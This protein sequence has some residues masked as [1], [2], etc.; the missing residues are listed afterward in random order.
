[1]AR[2]RTILLTGAAGV[3]GRAIAAQLDGHCIALVHDSRE[4]PEAGEVLAGDLS[5]PRLGLS[6]EDWHRL[7]GTVTAIVHS[8][9]LT[10]W[11]RPR[12]RYEAINLA[13]T[14]QVIELAQAAGA[15][16]YFISTI[17][18]LA[19]QR[20][21]DALKDDNVVRN[22]IWSKLE[23]ERL[24][25][26]S[27]VPHTIFRPTN[28]VGDSQ[29][30]ASL[31]PQIVQVLSDFIV[32]GKAPYFPSHPENLVD[33]A[34][35][36]YLA[37]PVARMAD[38]DLTGGTFHISYGDSAMSVDTALEVLQEHARDTGRQ[39]GRA[40]VVDPREPLPV[41]LHEI[42]ATSRPFVKV[43]IDV[44]EVTFASG[45]VLPSSLGELRERFDLSDTSP[46]VA[47]DRGLK[48]WAQQRG[49]LMQGVPSR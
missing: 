9:A 13:G 15:P 47:F 21:P 16:V 42:K 24:L 18:V 11:G 29:T 46:Q 20:S 49:Q 27:D 32:R 10:E 2:R 38:N 45:G 4:V 37:I 48:Y 28:L 40:A 12:E 44:S 5:T 7:A 39:I 30:G 41:P 35:L 1:M 26:A 14:R 19:L 6:R 36:D 17:F 33:I 25:Q 8:G 22:Y 23:S 43:G 34:P 3:V 31:R